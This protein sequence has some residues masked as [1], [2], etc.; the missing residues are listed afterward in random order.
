MLSFLSRFRRKLATR[1]API[2]APLRPEVPVQIIGDV[3]GRLDLLDRLMGQLDPDVITVQVGDLIDRGDHSA[4]VLARMREQTERGTWICLRGNHEEMMVNFLD[5]PAEAG[6]RWL[7]NGGLQTLASF[8]VGGVTQ[9]AEANALA[10]ARDALRDKMPAG[11]EDWLRRRPVSWN[12]GNLWVVHAGADP[13]RAMVEQAA[14][15]LVWGHPA[16][17]Q[18][19]RADGIWVAHGHTVVEQPTAAQGR[20]A[21]DT[22]AYFTGRL[23]CA[24]CLPSGEVSFRQI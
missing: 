11:L 2:P 9:M 4:E 20:I 15:H 13:Q 14:A 21:V 16:F 6:P 7:R 22:G 12:S 8:G 24:L 5:D 3:H 10:A 23:T 19:P 1:S 18:A 17:A